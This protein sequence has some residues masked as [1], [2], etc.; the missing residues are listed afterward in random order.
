MFRIS[1][2]PGVRLLTAIAIVALGGIAAL[3]SAVHAA[4]QIS[5]GTWLEDRRANCSNAQTCKLTFTAPQAGK[6]LIAR[7]VS[8]R[9]GVT[10]TSHAFSVMLETPS[11]VRRIFL[12]FGAPY[13]GGSTKQFNINTE[14]F[15]PFLSGQAPS[16][17]YT[18][19]AI[20]SAIFATCTLSGELKP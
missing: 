1:G 5:L 2:F 11:S 6:I 14:L 9:F 7:F 18:A 10:S 15:V 17:T 16:I 4:P 12:D 13:V 20:T 8:C 3:S 19:T